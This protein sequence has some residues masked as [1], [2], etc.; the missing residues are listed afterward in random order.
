M[1][2]ILLLGLAFFLLVGF[3]AAQP[4]TQF[5]RVKI[6]LGEKTLRDVGALGLEN[7][8]GMIIPGRFIINDYSAEEIA[9][10][11]EQGFIYE[12]LISDVQEWYVNQPSEEIIQFRNDCGE[13]ISYDYETPENYEY[14]SMGG[15]QTYDEMLATLDKMAEMYP[16]LISAKQPIANFLTHEGRPIY[17]LKISDNP[18]TDEGEPE[19]LYTAVHHAREPNSLSQLVFYLWYLLENYDNDPEIQFIIDHT[20]LYFIPCINPDGYIYNESTN[21]NGG[22]LWRKNRWT[23]PDGQTYGVDLNRNYGYEW[24]AD[25]SGSSPNPNSQVYR[26]ETPFSE[27]ETQAVKF[28]CEQHNFQV[29]FNYHSYGNLLIHPWGYNDTPTDEDDLFKGMG[30]V[31][32]RENNYTMGTGSET[33]G[34]V[35]NGGSDDWMYGETLTKNAIYSYT[36]EVGPGAVGFWPSEGMIDDLNKSAMWQN[37]AMALL[38]HNYVEVEHSLPN[39]IEASEGTEVLNITKLGLSPGS[40][41]ISV[42]AASA[43]L[44]VPDNELSYD[45]ASLETA[46]HTFSYQVQ[47]GSEV[48][49]AVKFAIHVDN[50][51]YISSDTIEV[52]YLNSIPNISYSDDMSDAS[53]WAA[54]GGWALTDADFV[55]ATTSMTDS[56]EGNYEDGVVNTLIL[57]SPF[58]LPE[59]EKAFLNYWARWEIE[60]GWDYVQ[61]MISTDGTN[62]TPLCGKYTR[63]GTGGFQPD[64]DPLYDGIQEEWV[65]EEVDISD[66]IGSDELYIQFQLNS[67]GYFNMDGFYFD[68]IQVSVLSDPILNTESP[69]Q[70]GKLDYFVMQPN[71]FTEQI[72]ADFVLAGDH[73]TASLRLLSPQG[74]VVSE[75]SMQQAIPGNR[76]R[77]SLDTHQLPNG[78][79]LVQLYA[80]GKLLRVEKA[81]KGK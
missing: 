7:D 18:E 73:K 36:P 79:Y 22:G 51:T 37:V 43:N 4:N 9:L 66:Y 1:K 8:H 52:S 54:S 62:F 28:F 74:A 58:S 40:N 11:D 47:P 6:K 16:N 63:P 60:E 34:Y 39:N 56:P 70:A 65:Y 12:V 33:V 48:L 29:A 20:E 50:G 24:G 10:L 81:V 3:A 46:T 77:L 59:G 15:Y 55:S 17:W 67:D 31:M 32:I 75:V 68:D 26:G 44:V 76:H 71:P 78:F 42:T 41:T 49:E 57:Q 45:L 5:S 27:P 25:D 2:R 19:V 14:G 30:N 53:Q 80:D 69:S 64:G 61:I 35:V 23:A 72:A 38:V 21:P 13:T